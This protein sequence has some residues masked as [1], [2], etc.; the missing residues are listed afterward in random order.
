VDILDEICTTGRSRR[1][2]LAV[3]LLRLFVWMTSH[4][5]EWTAL[6]QAR[7]SHG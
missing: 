4:E 2:R 1:E 5:R 3:A 7:T 6:M